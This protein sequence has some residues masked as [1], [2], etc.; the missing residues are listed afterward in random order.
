MYLTDAGFK[1][2]TFDDLLQAQ[3]TRCKAF[4]GEDVDT[5][6]LTA[7]GKFI[8]IIVYD[9]AEA[10]EDLELAYLAR[11][12]DTAT[13]ISLDRLCPF[14]GITRNPAT[15]AVHTVEFTCDDISG[16]ITVPSGTI[17]MTDQD[18]QFELVSDVIVAGNSTA[19]GSAV[20][21]VAGTVGNVNLNTITRIVNPVAFLKSVKNTA[22]TSF[23]TDTES[24]YELRKRWKIALTGSGGASASAIKG[25]IARMPNVESVKV[26]E[27]VQDTTDSAGRPPHSFECYVLATSVS[28]KAIAEAILRKKPIGIKAH[29]STVVTVQDDGGYNWNIGFTRVA[30]IYARVQITIKVD[31]DFSL[32]NGTEEIK[33]NIVEYVTG[34]GAGNPINTREMYSCIFKVIGVN[35]VTDIKVSRDNGASYSSGVIACTE[36]EAFRLYKTDISVTVV[37]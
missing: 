25:E 7:L 14:A 6:E 34:L 2:P 5:S 29:G 3:I 31:N 35:D 1:R 19:N 30:E 16:S 28:D 23:G 17:L 27:N 4:F 32:S 37:S 11:F 8:R 26:V 10:Y 36:G 24:D 20:C 18:V 21:T 12:P 22:I 33:N 15:S 13:G 9:L